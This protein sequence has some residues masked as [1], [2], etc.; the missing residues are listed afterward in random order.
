MYCVWVVAL[1][2][3]CH[4]IFLN[5]FNNDRSCIWS[6]YSWVIWPPIVVLSHC[7]VSVCS[8]F[9]IS[10]TLLLV[11]FISV[12]SSR[13][14]YWIFNLFI[15]LLDIVSISF[16]HF[17]PINVSLLID[18]LTLQISLVTWIQVI[19]AAFSKCMHLVSNKATMIQSDAKKA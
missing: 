6:W 5:W 8:E 11:I 16:L 3:L 13:D 10:K 7:E 1:Q 12:T 4:L 18:L 17:N 15:K 19:Q 14:I 9:W 2:L